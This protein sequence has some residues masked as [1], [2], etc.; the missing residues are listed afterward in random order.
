MPLYRFQY[1]KKGPARYIAHLDLM[2]VFERAARRAGLP[3]AFTGGFNPHPKISFAAP[4]AVGIEG[5]SEYVEI[6]LTTALPPSELAERLS[7]SM[8]AGI[9][10]KEAHPAPEGEVA[11]MAMVDRATYQ[12]EGGAPSALANLELESAIIDFLALPEIYVERTTKDG[13]QKRYDIRPGIIFM[14]GRLKDDI[15]FWE[16]E[17]KTGSA[18][19]IRVDEVLSAMRERYPALLKT[20]GFTVRRT[21]IKFKNAAVNLRKEESC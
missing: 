16:M 17:L 19:N 2:R 20:G 10:I 6:E 12:V 1:S 14:S 21:G 11:L 18:G 7:A 3:L 4:L 9:T 8:P 13:R 5:D 15:I